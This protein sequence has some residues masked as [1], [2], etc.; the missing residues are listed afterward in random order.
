MPKGVKKTTVK[1]QVEK[2]TVCSNCENSGMTCNTCG[3][4]KTQE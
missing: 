1:K 4:G 3:F 2:E